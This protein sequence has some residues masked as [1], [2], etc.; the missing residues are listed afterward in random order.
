MILSGV[1]WLLTWPLVIALSYF[2]IVW[3]LKHHEARLERVKTKVKVRVRTK[4]KKK[5]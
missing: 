3:A 5:N 2:L 4:I 1:L